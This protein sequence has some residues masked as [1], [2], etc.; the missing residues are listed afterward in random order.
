ESV[1]RGHPSGGFVFCHDF[2]SGFSDHFGMKEG[3]GVMRVAALNT[4]HSPW[5]ATARPFST[6]L[7]GEC[8]H[9][10]LWIN[11]TRG[12]KSGPKNHPILSTNQRFTGVFGLY[13]HYVHRTG[14]WVG[15][16]AG[17]AGAR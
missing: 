1:W 10:L 17:A 16:A 13:G 3:P 2:S 4:D 15:W 5:A 12:A 9:Q 11:P 8:I 7:I 6:N 14:V